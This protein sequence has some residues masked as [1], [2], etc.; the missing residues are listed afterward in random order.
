VQVR[1]HTSDL[2]GAGTDA[3]VYLILCGQQGSSGQLQL[4]AAGRDLF[5]R[6]TVDQFV[7]ESPPVGAISSIRI[8][9]D[10]K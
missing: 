8:G 2:R 7:V 4:E 9:H 10:N 3:G 1:V 6:G 5:E